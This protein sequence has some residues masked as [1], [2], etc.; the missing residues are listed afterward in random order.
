MYSILATSDRKPTIKDFFLTLV[1][2]SN[3]KFIVDKALNKTKFWTKVTD[4]S[5]ITLKA[6]SHYKPEIDSARKPNY[7][8][9][10]LIGIEHMNIGLALLRGKC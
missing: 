4:W 7:I 2:S 6:S 1:D 3:H 5:E 9:D 8:T 10:Y